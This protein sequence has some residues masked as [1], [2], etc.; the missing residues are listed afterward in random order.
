MKT[1]N[2][3]SD[4]SEDADPVKAQAQRQRD[5]LIRRF[6]LLPHPE[7]GFYR[8]TYRADLRVN[9]RDESVGDQSNRSAPATYAASTAIYYLL[10]D[11]A[12][13]AWHRIRSDEIWHFYTG[14]PI[15]IHVLRADGSQ[16]SHRLGNP[17][18]AANP[19]SKVMFQVVVAAGDWFAA[20]RVED[21]HGFALAG[22]TV[23]PGFEFADFE[24][25]S[26]DA[27]LA[28]HPQHEGMI[29]QFC[30][31]PSSSK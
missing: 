21:Q 20:G 11:G 1:L 16:V 31:V 2:P 17:L 10:C 30:G 6:N 25:A 15:D 13:S 18:E 24:I 23:A 26:L 28:S 22:C 3:G 14:D 8:E 29:R 19:S 7:G 4:Y 27:L 12:Y 9:R 5:E